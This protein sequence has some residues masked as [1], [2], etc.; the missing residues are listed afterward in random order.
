MRCRASKR[1]EQNAVNA[2]AP[3]AQKTGEPVG[4][5]DTSARLQVMQGKLPHPVAG[6]NDDR[7]GGPHAGSPPFPPCLIRPKCGLSQGPRAYLV[8]IFIQ[9]PGGSAIPPSVS[10]SAIF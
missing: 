3:S 7:P 10:I 2:D 4:T 1:I 9:V 8:P 6:P 5:S